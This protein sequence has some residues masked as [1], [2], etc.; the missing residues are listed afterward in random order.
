MT[1][2]LKLT[3]LLVLPAALLAACAP[4][5]PPPPPQPVYVAPPAPA[6]APMVPRARG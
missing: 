6:P 3:A 5:P 4:N 2:I 1:S